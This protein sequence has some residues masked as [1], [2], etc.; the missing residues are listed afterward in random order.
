MACPNSGASVHICRVSRSTGTPARDESRRPC[1]SGAGR[2][3]SA[4]A[5]ASSREDGRGPPPHGWDA[6]TACARSTRDG[7]PHSATE[8]SF[9]HP[10]T[11]VSSELRTDAPRRRPWTP[12]PR[13]RYPQ[14]NRALHRSWNRPRIAVA[15]V[16]SSSTDDRACAAERD[17]KQVETNSHGASSDRT[18][19]EDMLAGSGLRDYQFKTSPA[20]ASGHQ[21]ST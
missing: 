8:G 3:P 16:E 5:L 17:G 21:G 18:R 14:A 13:D 2:R 7:I 1:P 6:W 9:E 11:T 12:S 15:T 19:F 20:P 4:D 10:Q